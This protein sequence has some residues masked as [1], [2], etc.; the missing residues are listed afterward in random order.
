MAQEERSSRP[1]QMIHD[2]QEQAY[3]WHDMAMRAHQ[4]VTDADRETIRRRFH[5][6]VMNYWKCL[7]RH[8]RSSHVRQFWRGRGLIPTPGGGDDMTLAELGGQRFET[9]R[10]D[11]GG[12]DHESG[13]VEGAEQ[14]AKALS[15]RQ[16]AAALEALD[17]VANALAFDAQAKEERPR[18]TPVEAE[19]GEG[20]EVP[21]DA[22]A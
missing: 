14:Q 11:G 18:S 4:G 17:R 22:V 7:E 1:R 10:I 3:R 19:D 16:S 15:I 13:E 8:S 5:T 9:E 21:E 6:A 2:A 12:F 20:V